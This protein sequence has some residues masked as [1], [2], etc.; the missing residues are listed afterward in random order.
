LELRRKHVLPDGVL[1]AAGRNRE[2]NLGRASESP[3]TRA[4][5]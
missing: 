1:E 2:R 3:S 5:S 4:P